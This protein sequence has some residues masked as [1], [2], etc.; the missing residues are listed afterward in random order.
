MTKTMMA[1]SLAVL[2]PLTISA[3]PALAQTRAVPTQ[4]IVVDTA[5][6]FSECTACKSAQAQLKTQ[7]DA[8]QVRQRT[9][10]A[11]LQTEGQALQTAVNALAGKEPDAALRARATSFQQRQQAAQVEVARSEETFNRNRAF[12]AQQIG[13]RL[14]PIIVATMKARGAN[15]AVDPQSVLAYEPGLDVTN[16][17]LAQLNTALP[18]VSVTAPPA[19]AQPARSATQGR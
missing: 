4:A 12:V 3:V 9:L 13:Q 18:S 14:N 16:D 5:R 10:S 6:V 15:V 17:V 11:P 19:P 1:A 8:I 7:V 2:A